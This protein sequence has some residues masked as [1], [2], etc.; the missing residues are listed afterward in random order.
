MKKLIAM[1]LFC[2]ST[3]GA[4][5]VVYDEDGKV[6]RARLTGNGLQGERVL[7]YRNEDAEYIPVRNILL[8]TSRKWLRVVDGEL[9]ELS[10]EEKDAI[11]AAEQAAAEAAQITSSRAEAV[12]YI[13]AN[14]GRSKL[15]RAALKLIANSLVE[16]RSKVNE[17]AAQVNAAS[18]SSIEPL[19]NRDWND[20]VNAVQNI[21][22]SRQADE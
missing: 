15:I 4:I 10:Q 8:S 17:I 12:G 18:G 2:A 22:E 13:T 7:V 19:P 3:F 14:D 5:S 16:T 11:I 1:L 20:L 6:T 9:T 21:I